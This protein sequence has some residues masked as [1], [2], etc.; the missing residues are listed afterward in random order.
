MMQENWYYCYNFLTSSQK[1]SS[2]RTY[3]IADITTATSCTLK[4]SRNISRAF[5]NSDVKRQNVSTDDVLVLLF[6]G[7]DLI[8][9]F[10]DLTQQNKLNKLLMDQ[11]SYAAIDHCF[12]WGVSI[13]E[14]I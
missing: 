5:N 3:C 9:V 14:G 1:S 12:G 2:H 10:I 13:D 7:E 4:S 8:L 11:T 6:K